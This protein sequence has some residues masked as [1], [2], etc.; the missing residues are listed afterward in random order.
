MGI[1]ILPD[2][3]L[4]Q[5][6][7]FLYIKK[8]KQFKAKLPILQ[9]NQKIFLSQKALIWIVITQDLTP[10]LLT[11]FSFLKN[12]TTISTINSAI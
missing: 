5:L 1:A 2:P 6:R 7:V 4:F 8:K 3:F 11:F 10:L 9:I 12:R